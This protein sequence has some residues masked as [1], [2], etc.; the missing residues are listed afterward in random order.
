M[1]LHLEDVLRLGEDGEEV[2]VR[3]E[4]EAAEHVALGLEV[5]VEALLNLNGVEESECGAG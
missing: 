3:E 1:Y 4:V 5:L 2:I